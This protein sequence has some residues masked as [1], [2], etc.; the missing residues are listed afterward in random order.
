MGSKGAMVEK[1]AGEDTLFGKHDLAAEEQCVRMLSEN[2]LGQVADLIR[3]IRAYGREPVGMVALCLH[4]P[5]IFGKTFLH[6]LA[7]LLN[8]FRAFDAV[9]LDDPR[10]YEKPVTESV[11]EEPPDTEQ[12]MQPCTVEAGH[13]EDRSLSLGVVRRG[14]FFS[15]APGFEGQRSNVAF[16]RSAM[17]WSSRDSRLPVW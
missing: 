16:R 10:L 4:E 3:D 13:A 5:D 1:E 15:L 14:R 17:R 2:P 12:G 11:P 9:S 8:S 6:V 7:M